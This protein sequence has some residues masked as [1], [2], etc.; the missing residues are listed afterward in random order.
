[1]IERYEDAN[2]GSTAAVE[3][4][5]P[6]RW[7][8]ACGECGWLHRRGPTLAEAEADLAVHYE[9]DHGIDVGEFVWEPR[10]TDLTGPAE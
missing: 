5:S 8:M 10:H 1:M 2:T 6:V 3:D 4:T 7:R 9:T